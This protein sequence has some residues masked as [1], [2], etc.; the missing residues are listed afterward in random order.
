MDIAD[1]ADR[2]IEDQL[3]TSLQ[4]IQRKKTMLLEPSGCCD[5]CGG[6][7]P[8]ARQLAVPGCSHCVCCADR[9]E[10][11]G[12]GYSRSTHEVLRLAVLDDYLYS[13]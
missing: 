12:S 4:A 6:A 9:L 2:F 8:E 3:L 1:M 13:I 5:E 7:I 10:R 11:L